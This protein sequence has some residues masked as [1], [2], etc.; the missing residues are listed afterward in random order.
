M[1]L[2]LSCLVKPCKL[3]RGLIVTILQTGETQHSME[4]FSD[5]S[6]VSVTGN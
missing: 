2:F 1:L 3:C 6:S 4:F 5:Y